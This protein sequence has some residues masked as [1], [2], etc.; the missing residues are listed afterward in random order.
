MNLKEPGKIDL[1][2]LKWVFSPNLS[3]LLNAKDVHEKILQLQQDW[4]GTWQLFRCF[5]MQMWLL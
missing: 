3:R 5:G 1:K 2:H 4:F